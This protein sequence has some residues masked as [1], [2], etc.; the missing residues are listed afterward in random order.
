MNKT[1]ARDLASPTPSSLTA[2]NDATT[3]GARVQKQIA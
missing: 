1:T 3:S 2:I